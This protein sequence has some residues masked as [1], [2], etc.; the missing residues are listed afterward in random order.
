VALNVILNGALRYCIRIWITYNYVGDENK[1]K[2]RKKK[3]IDVDTIITVTSKLNS[4]ISSGV[5]IAWS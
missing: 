3:V 2:C 4:L 5:S 1:F